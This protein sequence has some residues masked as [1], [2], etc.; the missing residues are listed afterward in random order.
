VLPVLAMGPIQ[1]RAELSGK[2]GIKRTK[3]GLAKEGIKG[4]EEEARVIFI[5]F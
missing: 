2:N 3:K 1:K 5:D 4:I